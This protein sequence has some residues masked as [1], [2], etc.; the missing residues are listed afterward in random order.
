MVH[1]N[2]VAP[3]RNASTDLD[4]GSA[5]ALRFAD[6][7]ITDRLGTGP[8]SWADRYALHFDRSGI[9]GRRVFQF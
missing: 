8:V 3:D 2:E 9:L 6:R 5:T 4:V 7:G 1:E